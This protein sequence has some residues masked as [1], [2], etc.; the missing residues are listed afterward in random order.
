[1]KI[2]L[3]AAIGK[4]NQIGLGGEIPWHDT[5]DLQ[6]FKYLTLGK[7]VVMGRK[8]YESIGKCL[9]GRHNIVVSRTQS[10]PTDAFCVTTIQQAIDLSTYL[11]TTEMMVIGGER[12]Y[13]DFMDKADRMYLT[14]TEYDDQADTFFP[15]IKGEWYIDYTEDDGKFKILNRRLF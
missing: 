14:Y 10:D 8:T 13:R 5:K 11:K 6:R 2:S 12:M 1:M 3:I 7:T 9:P 15:E 4:H